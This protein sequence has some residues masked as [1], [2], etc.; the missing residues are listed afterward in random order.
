[1]RW[2]IEGDIPDVPKMV[3]I[4]TP[5]TSNWDFVVGVAAKLA[6][7]LRIL[8]LGKDTLFRFPLGMLMRG[9]GGMPVDRASPH[10]V[11]NQVRVEFSRR[12]RLIVG[13][14]P[15]GTRKRV[16]RWRTGFYH[17]AHGAGVPILPVA[18]DWENRVIRIHQ[19]AAT[20]GNLEADVADLQR[21]LSGARGK[22]PRS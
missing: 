22:R 19:P 16:E 15:E 18:L 10:D 3:I 12:D 9:L 2:R 20:T 6:L 4:V 11:V 8:F 21:R 17:I 5:H 13:L 1:M 7:G 14:A